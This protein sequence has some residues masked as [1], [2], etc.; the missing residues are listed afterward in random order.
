VGNSVALC[1]RGGP[2]VLLVPEDELEL[3]DT[4]F[5]DSVETFVSATLSTIAPVSQ[6]ILPRLAAVLQKVKISVGPIGIESQSSSQA[7]SYLAVH[8]YGND[9]R[10]MLQELLPNR[11]L[12]PADEWIARAKS[13]KTTFEITRISQA[14]AIAAKSYERAVPELRAGLSEPDAAELLRAPLNSP[15]DFSQ[16]IQ[17][18]NGFAF[19]MSGPNSAKASAAYARTRSRILEPA[20]LVMMHCNSCV[21]GFWTDITRTYTLQPPDKQQEKMYAAVHAARTAALS[22]IKPGARAQAIDKAA[23]KTIQDFGLGTYLRHGTGHGVGFSPMSAYNIPRIHAESPDVLEEGMVFN[24]EPAVYID[25]YGGVR[26][27]DMVA[28]TN[29]GHTLLTAFQSDIGSLAITRDHSARALAS[30]ARDAA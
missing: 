28:V 20:D 25:G 5:A 3:A 10:N 26:H 18:W 14:C 2:I 16:M 22:L 17:R 21:D 12:K 23:R 24:I 4:S 6:A 19:C 27:C 9:I 15:G 1:I 30:G 29:S 11:A 13:V 7:A 8:L